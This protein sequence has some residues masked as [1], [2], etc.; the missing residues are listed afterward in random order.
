MKVV[1]TYDACECCYVLIGAGVPCEHP[2]CQGVLLR[3][4]PEGSQLHSAGSDAGE[5][6]TTRTGCELCG[7]GRGL[8]MTCYQVIELGDH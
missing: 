1:A 5:P 2:Q 4:A 8:L 3:L 6:G 7:Q